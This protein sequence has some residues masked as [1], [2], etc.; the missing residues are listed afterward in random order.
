MESEKPRA[1][2]QRGIATVLYLSFPHSNPPGTSIPYV[3][4]L[5]T[6]KSRSDSP[7]L[8]LP[9]QS[10]L[11]FLSLSCSVPGNPPT[12]F[13]LLSM[14]AVAMAFVHLQALD[15]KPQI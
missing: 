14:V 9:A 7:L 4:T 8:S 6:A 12:P 2:S 10:Y 3:Q 13:L 15:R 11:L 5:L 1:T